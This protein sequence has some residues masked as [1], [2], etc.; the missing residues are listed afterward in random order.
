MLGP[1]PNP[2]EVSIAANR[3]LM[4]AQ[5]HDGVMSHI[6]ARRPERL[7]YGFQT[8]NHFEQGWTV[9]VKGRGGAQH[10]EPRADSGPA[11]CAAIGASISNEGASWLEAQKSPKRVHFG[12]NVEFQRNERSYSPC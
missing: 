4:P 11:A 8:E 9:A 7:G 2:S 5:L 10:S 1:G 12:T 6:A 3:I